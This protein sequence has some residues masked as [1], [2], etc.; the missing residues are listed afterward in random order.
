M[1]HALTCSRFALS[2]NRFTSRANQAQLLVRRSGAN[3]WRSIDRA[4]L[5]H[6]NRLCI[7]SERAR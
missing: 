7:K 2:A 3:P 5:V 1:F 4:D 6:Y